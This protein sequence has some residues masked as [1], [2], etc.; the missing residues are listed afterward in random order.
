MLGDAE[1]LTSIV[2]VEAGVGLDGV[3]DHLERERL[4]LASLQLSLCLY[5]CS[6]LAHRV[7]VRRCVETF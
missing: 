7:V 2:E 3:A 4:S 1:L 5:V 6:G